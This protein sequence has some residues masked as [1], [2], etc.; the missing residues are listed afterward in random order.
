[1]ESKPPPI[2]QPLLPEIG[3]RAKSLTQFDW[4]DVTDDSGV[5]YSLQVANANTFAT[6]SI[7]L[8]QKGL[9]QSGYILTKEEALKSRSANEPYYWRVRAVDGAGNESDWTGGN[10][11]WVGRSLP[12]WTVHLFW[13]LGVVGAVFFGYFLGKRRGYY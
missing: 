2:P 7:V 3:M 10:D 1:M 8:D 4:G 9:T 13:G 6:G 5:T 11:F 12:S